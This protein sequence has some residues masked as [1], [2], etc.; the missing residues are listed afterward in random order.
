MELVAGLAVDPDTTENDRAQ[1]LTRPSP[2]CTLAII[3]RPQWMT[4]YRDYK[5]TSAR[6]PGSCP[7]EAGC[8]KMWVARRGATVSAGR[9]ESP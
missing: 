2:S 7:P 1:K 9:T 6:R 3:R 5:G 8:A 4:S